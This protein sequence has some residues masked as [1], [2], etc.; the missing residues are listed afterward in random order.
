MNALSQAPSGGSGYVPQ[1]NS[2]NY[3]PRPP[4]A[5]G[6]VPGKINAGAFKPRPRGEGGD[7]EDWGEQPVEWAQ[8]VYGG[9]QHGSPALPPQG[10]WQGQG[11]W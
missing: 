6:Y 7:D 11:Q 1:Y 9:P 5:G 8:P 3:A 2:Y 10:Q 4:Q